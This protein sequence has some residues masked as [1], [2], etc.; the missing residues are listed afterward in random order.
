MAVVPMQSS[1]DQAGSDVTLPSRAKNWPPRRRELLH[2]F[3]SNAPPLAGAYEGAIGLLDADDFPGR[4]HFIAHAVRD[5]ADRLVFV[6]DPQL[7]GN[8]VQYEN[9]MDKI[10]KLWPELETIQETRGERAARDE[11]TIDYRLA[12]MVDSLVRAHRER[13]QRP[14]NHE[15]LF[16]F[17]MRQEPSQGD[18]NQRLVS[19]FK[20]T[21]NWFMRWT[22]LRNND[23]PQVDEGELRNQFN[24]FEGML[25]SFVGGFFTGTRELD[26]ILQQ[27]NK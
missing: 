1:S 8:R 22:H 26:E 5:I 4:V 27:A 10:E 7:E 18:V 15:L 2:W 17:L 23:V 19:D 3:H 20:K 21:R 12:L 25:H 14:S 11:F 24:G 13:R 16:R 9:E 6:L